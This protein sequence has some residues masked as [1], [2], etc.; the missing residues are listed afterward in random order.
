MLGSAAAPVL[1]LSGLAAAH[2]LVTGLSVDLVASE[3]TDVQVCVM[4][5]GME[6]ID[7]S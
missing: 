4:S 6:T 1:R 2:P 5:L 3:L 7:L